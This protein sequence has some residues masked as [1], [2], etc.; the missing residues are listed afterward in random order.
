[1]KVITGDKHSSLFSLNI[2]DT[3]CF[4]MWT[5]FDFCLQK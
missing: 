4:E 1:V 3:Y 2:V 5:S